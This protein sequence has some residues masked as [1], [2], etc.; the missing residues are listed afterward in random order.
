MPTGGNTIFLDAFDAGQQLSKDLPNIIEPIRKSVSG[1]V[2]DIK[3]VGEKIAK[4]FR[5]A[6][7]AIVDFTKGV[8]SVNPALDSFAKHVSETTSKVKEKFTELFDKFKESSGLA[9]PF[10][11]GL[12]AVTGIVSG[13]WKGVT[14]F[15]KMAL[16]AASFREESVAGFK[17]VL[18]NAEAANTLFNHALEV[19]KLTKYE[20]QDVVTMYNGLVA[21]G[22]KEEELDT[23]TAAISDVSSA[24]GEA[25]G[26]RYELALSKLRG[27]GVAKFGTYQQAYMSGAGAENT[28]KELGKIL[29]LKETDPAKLSAKIN[30]MMKAK[31]ITSNQAILANFNAVQGLY[32][33]D[34]KDDKGNTKKGKLGDYSLAQSQTISGLF[35]T[36]KSAFGDLVMGL[37]VSNLPG[38]KSFREFLK[39]N[40]ELLNSSTEEGKRLQNIV[41]DLIN[42]IF[43]VFDINPEKT[44][45]GFGVIL[46]LAEKIEKRIKIVAAFIRDDLIPSVLDMI[47]SFTDGGS[48][49]SKIKQGFIA[50]AKLAGQA[51]AVGFLAAMGFE[52]RSKEV[53]ESLMNS[54]KSKAPENRGYGLSP[55]MQNMYGVYSDNP[56]GSAPKASKD[57]GKD[58]DDFG[59]YEGAAKG[60]GRA[61]GYGFGLGI[62]QGI[63][64]SK[65]IVKKAMNG[66]ATEPEEQLRED[67]DTHSP[68]GLYRKLGRDWGDGLTLGIADRFN[69]VTDAVSKMQQ[70]SSDFSFEDL[71]KDL[72]LADSRDWGLD[73]NDKTKALSKLVSDAM[74]FD[75]T[76]SKEQS[77]QSMPTIQLNQQITALPGMDIE[78]LADLVVEKIR[79]DLGMG[80]GRL[81]RS[82]S[83]SNL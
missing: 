8:R 25:A 45:K 82:P 10:S 29:G 50:L 83:A 42:D 52:D 43:S 7:D 35:S 81:L 27:A 49:M 34:T 77:G 53:E 73:L 69:N 74:G 20:T 68:S 67:T 63:E 1:L 60:G 26:K 58:W 48:F 4:P 62:A 17:A 24:R 64:E 70:I 12:D 38:I 23:V 33:P 39:L 5:T 3:D 41:K 75:N 21:K 18:G 66:L 65:P 57:M 6:K 13:L 80:S 11:L 40:L 79:M 37:D 56:D 30:D 51:L 71:D 15:A 14:A 76:S 32:D 16:D 19:A 61:V 36:A 44:K 22:F 46:D 28:N 54:G 31:K 78:E 2:S 9:S 59:P 55:A 47:G 72:S